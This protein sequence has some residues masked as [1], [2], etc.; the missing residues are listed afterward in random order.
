MPAR[1]NPHTYA[2]FIKASGDYAAEGGSLYQWI[3]THWQVVP[4]EEAYKDGYA[5]LVANDIENA[6][7]ENAKKAVSSTIL[8]VD[9]MP[10]SPA[11][12]VIPCQ[13]GYVHLVDGVP[14]LR[15]AERQLGIKHVSSCSFLPDAEPPKRFQQFLDTCLPD[16]QVQGRV[17]EY[18]GYTFLPDARYQRA[19]CWIGDGANGKGVLSNIVQSLH[20]KVAAAKLHSLDKFLLSSL[21][22]ASLI[23]VDEAPKGRIDEDVLKSLIPGELVQID[24]KNRDPICVRI[25]GKWLVCGN[26]M[27]AVGDTSDG[28]WRKWDFVP[29]KTTIPEGQRD[30]LLAQSIIEHELP[31]VLNWALDGLVRLQRRGQFEPVLPRP[32][33]NLMERAR[34]ENDSIRAWIDEY[35]ITVSAN[36]STLKDQVYH[37]YRQWCLDSGMTAFAMPKFWKGLYDTLK[38]EVERRREN[39]GQHRYCNLDIPTH[40]R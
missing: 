1:F 15:P 9:R 27:P 2:T 16:Q 39:G 18:I 22:G 8:W 24:R 5:W 11:D 35:G 40:A 23:V 6:S 19:Q 7:A 29:F 3:G 13:N 38:V 31:G 34:Q 26:H 36:I 28:F 37:H 33:Q 10:T 32:M 30:P 4:D 12:V 20:T 21:I 25:L 17:Q 14:T